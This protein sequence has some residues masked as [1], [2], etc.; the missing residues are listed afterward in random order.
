MQLLNKDIAHEND[1]HL[2]EVM[3]DEYHRLN[4]ELSGEESQT[5]TNHAII[6]LA[7]QRRKHGCPLVLLSNFVFEGFIASLKRQYHET[8]GIVGQMVSNI[9]LLQNLKGIG[10]QVE[11]PAYKLL[12]NKIIDRPLPSKTPVAD[13]V[14]LYGRILEEMPILLDLNV[15]QE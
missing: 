9:G 10:N 6:H 14:S 11:D 8:R 5:F 4:G 2:A 15:P 13:G 7:D 12:A 3:I 1:I